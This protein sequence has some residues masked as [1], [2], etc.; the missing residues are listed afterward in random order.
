[1]PRQRRPINRR[2]VAKLRRN[3]RRPNSSHTYTVHRRCAVYPKTQDTTW[4]DTLAWYGSIA[5]QLVKVLY[6]VRDDLMTTSVIT[7]A[8]STMMLG[9]ADFAAASPAAGQIYTDNDQEIQSCRVLPYERASLKRITVKIVP[10]VDLGARGGMY[11]AVLIP[12]DT[13]ASEI[14]GIDYIKRF[15]CDYESL[16]KHPDAKLAPVTKPLNLHLTMRHRPC[17]LNTKWDDTIGYRN[18]YPACA[19]M[20]AYSDLADKLEAIPGEYT[21]NRSLFEVHLMGVVTM[22]EPG[23]MPEQH[24]KTNSNDSTSTLKIW[25][26]N[27]TKKTKVER[28]PK[29]IVKFFGHTWETEGDLDLREIDINIAEKILHHY[30]RLDLIPKL[31]LLHAER[32]LR[33]FEIVAMDG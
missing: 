24:K 17:D 21:P 11:V 28:P 7:S 20:V 25:N 13:V 6:G 15:T 9:P 27:L 4:L 18:C 33:S 22:Y 1:M 5:L 3:H 10:S 14:F 23:E 26:T 31:R 29:H 2:R 12:V 16:V 32:N 30:D 8:G 19:L